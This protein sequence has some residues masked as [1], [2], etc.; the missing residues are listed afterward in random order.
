MRS[1]NPH[2]IRSSSLTKFKKKKK[3]YYQNRNDTKI[4]QTV[5]S[6]K[7]GVLV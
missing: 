6:W 5:E 2:Q 4:P 3:T 1:A 7:I